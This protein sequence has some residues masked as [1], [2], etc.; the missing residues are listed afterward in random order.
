MEL[1]KWVIP[2]VVGIS[3]FAAG[4]GAGLGIAK[5]RQKKALERGESSKIEEV[6]SQITQLS[7]MFEETDRRFDS[8]IQQGHRVVREMKEHLKTSVVEEI[9]DIVSSREGHPSNAA[10]KLEVVGDNIFEASVTDDWDWEEE[11]ANRGPNAPY[12]LHRDEFF[13][14]ENDLEQSSITYYKGDDVLCDEKD[15]PIYSPEKVVGRLEF[16]HGSQDPNVVYIRN[17]ELGAEWEVLLD[18]GYYAV[19]VL[20]GQIEDSMKDIRHSIRKFKMD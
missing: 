17:E 1:R 15:V 12:I 14:N 11:L 2:T 13:S 10:T 3:S 4:I 5:Y 7:F 6:E 16:G 19:E 8:L 9:E 18:H 20:G